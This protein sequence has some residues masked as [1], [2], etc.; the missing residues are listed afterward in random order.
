MNPFLPLAI[1]SAKEEMR[2]H[3]LYPDLP[4]C[5]RCSIEHVKKACCLWIFIQTLYAKRLPE[6]F[7]QGHAVRTLIAVQSLLTS[8]IC[9]E[10][11]PKGIQYFPWRSEGPACFICVCV[12]VCVYK[13]SVCVLHLK[14]RSRCLYDRF[15]GKLCIFMHRLWTRTHLK[16]LVVSE[17][18]H[19]T[20]LCTLR[21]AVFWSVQIYLIFL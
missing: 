17:L 7:L 20:L 15:F 10:K 2:P 12:S 8:D 5:R 9:T 6:R 1:L 13:S 3:K 19:Y 18:P 11:T 4:D 14:S 21:S 16:A